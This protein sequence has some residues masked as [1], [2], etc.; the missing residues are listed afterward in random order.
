MVVL[1]ARRFVQRKRSIVEANS[2]CQSPVLACFLPCSFFFP[3][4]SVVL[5]SFLEFAF[6]SYLYLNRQGS[7]IKLYFKACIY[8]FLFT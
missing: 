1:E 4:R 2:F 3:V 7:R 5:F 8:L 6:V